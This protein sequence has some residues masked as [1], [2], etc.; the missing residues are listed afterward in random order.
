MPLDIVVAVR[1]TAIHVAGTAT[2]DLS[3]DV[4]ARFKAGHDAL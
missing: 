1:D 3:K 4:D 2:G